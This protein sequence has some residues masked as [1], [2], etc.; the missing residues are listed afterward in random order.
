MIISHSELVSH[1]FS[2]RSKCYDTAGTWVKD[3]EVLL[4]IQNF[5][6]SSFQNGAILDL[7]SG[8]GAV[9]KYLL[10]QCGFHHVV[11]VD[12]CVEMLS[13]N[14]SHKVTFV[15]SNVEKLPFLDES[16]DC[17]VSRQCLHYVDKI[18]QALAEVYRV[19]KPGGIFILAQIVPYD[20]ET[21]P[22]WKQIIE[23][24]QPLRRWYKSASDWDDVVTKAGLIKVDSAKN[25]HRSSLKKWVR[26]YEIDDNAVLE[27]MRSLLL[28]ADT[29]Y[30]TIYDIKVSDDDISYLA[31]WHIAKY[32]K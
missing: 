19:L 2:Q 9:S 3:K 23:I 18:D 10:E 28:S 11:A 30:Q 31:F 6:P 12:N 27:K 16:F 32:V 8:T 20:N 25:K 4:H 13:R 15:V 14:K 7:G 22:Y 21:K 26:K 5:L 24:H 17:V 1:H 29:S